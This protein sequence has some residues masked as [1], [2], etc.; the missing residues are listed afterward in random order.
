MAGVSFYLFPSHSARSL[1]NDPLGGKV[2][3]PD[4]HA[5]NS[6]SATSPRYAFK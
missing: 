5:E 1:S 4:G 6:H 3:T 2:S